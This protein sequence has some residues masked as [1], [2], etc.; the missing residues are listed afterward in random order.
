MKAKVTG[1][2]S[3]YFIVKTYSMKTNVLLH[4]EHKNDVTIIVNFC[5][6]LQAEAS[7]RVTLRS[8]IMIVTSHLCSKCKRTQVSME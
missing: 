8:L 6:E 1:P 2:M 4:F 5:V 7:R 3:N